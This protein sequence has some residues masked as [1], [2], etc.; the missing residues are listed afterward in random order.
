[1]D[2]TSDTT[3]EAGE[4][5]AAAERVTHAPRPGVTARGLI[6]LV[7]GYQVVLGPLLGGHCRFSPT[8]SHYAIQALTIHGARRGAWLTVRRLAKCH[9]WERLGGAS[10]EDPVPG[11]RERK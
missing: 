4:R 6:A 10:G 3:V 9:P 7:R 8:C 2:E 5:R 1:M 11:R